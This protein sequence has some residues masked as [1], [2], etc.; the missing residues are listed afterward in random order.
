MQQDS[1]ATSS[2]DFAI[3]ANSYENQSRWVKDKIINDIP[4]KYLEILDDLGD[5]LDAGGGTGYLST[6]IL[7]DAKFRSLTIVD[8]SIEMLAI[9][10]QRNPRAILINQPIET[11]AKNSDKR[12]DIVLARQILHYVNDVDIVLDALNILLKDNG[13]LY[14]GQF[15]V[16]DLAS[17]KWHG[18]IIHHISKNR[19]RSFEFSSFL[20][21]FIDHGFELIFDDLTPYEENI[22]NFYNRRINNISFSEL[23]RISKETLT[24][25][26]RDSLKISVTDDNLFFT[27]SF[28]HMLLRKRR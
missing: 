14:I 17:D 27:V 26:V 8:A 19:K 12:Y 10:K 18:N 11:Y 9:A 5:V 28:C 13:Y 16:P 21:V 3:R 7:E 25:K 6:Y 4:K 1:L 15:I 24:D 2:V 22:K 20:N 23:L